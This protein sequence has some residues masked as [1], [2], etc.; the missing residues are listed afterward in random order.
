MNRIAADRVT[1]RTVHDRVVLWWRG[2]RDTGSGSN[3]LG[4]PLAA[5]AHLIAV[6]AKQPQTKA[7]QPGEIETTGTLTGALS[8]R[9]GE[10]WGTM[11]F[12]IARPRIPIAPSTREVWVSCRS[13]RTQDLKS[14][15]C[16]AGWR[17]DE[18]RVTRI[19]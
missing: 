9:G 17:S 8:I 6:L 11:I 14:P 16:L 19:R 7:L 15:S 2:V 1:A 13:V 10:T 12:G 4:S 5:A 18:E 3:V